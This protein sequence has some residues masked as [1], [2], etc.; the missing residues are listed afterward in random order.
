MCEVKDHALITLAV[1]QIIFHSHSSMVSNLK[2]SLQELQGEVYATCKIQQFRG[3][4]QKRR[5][6]H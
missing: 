1:T 2:N 5:E 4:L 6:R 3:G